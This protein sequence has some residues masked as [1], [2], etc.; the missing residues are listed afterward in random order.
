MLDLLEA[1]AA[2]SDDEVLLAHGLDESKMGE[3]R[4]PTTEE[5][6]SA[7]PGRP[8]FIN[9]RGLHYVVCSSACLAFLGIDPASNETG[10]FDEASAGEVRAAL[11]SRMTIEQRRNF[12]RGAAT[13]MAEQGF[14]SVHAIEGGTLSDDRDIPILLG[15]SSSLPISVC[16]Y[17]NTTETAAVEEAGL[18]RMGGDI[19]VDG[20]LGARTALLSRPYADD[21]STSGR[22]FLTEDEM[23]GLIQDA[24][25]R[26]I[27]ISFHAI[28]DRAIEIALAAFSAAAAGSDLRH[29]IEHFGL[30]GP[31]QIDRAHALGLIISTQPSFAYLRGGPGSVY[32]RRLG[33]DRAARA[34]GLR[35]LAESG[36]AVAAG[37]DAPVTPPDPLLGIA[38]CAGHP[39]ESERIDVETG[40]DWFTRGGAY[41][42]GEEAERGLLEPGMIADLVLL[43]GDLHSIEPTEAGE[44]GIELTVSRGR[45]V[46]GRRAEAVG[47]A[48]TRR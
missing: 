25:K 46:A 16:L 23:A 7:I 37:T 42:G 38:A 19:F 26:G 27:Q 9:D 35:A 32:E 33:A 22:Q 12:L 6:D 14:T 4:A 13:H 3:G 36:V 30:A 44:L 18:S 45:I 1:R 43:D 8:I 39:T 15:E 2:T 20:S 10:R 29:R 40:L 17:W 11:G 24:E 21:P 5:L 34:Y 31:E 28:G 47:T 48:M 41:A